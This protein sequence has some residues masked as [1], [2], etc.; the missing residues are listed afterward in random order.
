MN[1]TAM[2]RKF[3]ND[4]IEKNIDSIL[5][6]EKN[7]GVPY[8]FKFYRN[9][10]AS[11]INSANNEYRKRCGKELELQ[12]KVKKK[13]AKVQAK[14]NEYQEKRRVDEELKKQLVDAEKREK[15]RVAKENSI[16]EQNLLI[17]QQ[18][19]V[20]T[21]TYLLAESGYHSIKITL[22]RNP[23]YIDAYKGDMPSV[24]YN[25]GIIK[26][27]KDDGVYIAS[28]SSRASFPKGIH[29][30]KIGFLM[31]ILAHILV[32]IDISNVC[33]R[34]SLIQN[35][36]EDNGILLQTPDNEFEIMQDCL[37]IPAVYSEKNIILKLF[38]DKLTSTQTEFDNM[39]GHKFEYF[40]AGLL[41]KN[42]FKDVYITRGSGDQGID[43][44]AYKDEIKYGIQC[45]CYSSAVGNKA[46]Q[47]VFAGRTFYSCHVGVVLTN[48][49]FTESAKELAR[50]NGVLLWDRR[51]LLELVEAAHN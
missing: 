17:H 43:I 7:H 41:K 46:V 47:E 31:N 30:T 39:D 24:S 10:I 11:L 33:E 5:N 1:I 8:P 4:V 18:K 21:C 32:D 28:F 19:A 16:V 26:A 29:F 38:T 45:K 51:K 14:Y 27:T 3:Y 48:Q 20:D 25:A 6:Y 35:F 49:F 42:G 36:L 23:P 2:Y 15:E 13:Y 34:N 44:V 40:C 37:Y 9:D 22:K 12:P 50:K